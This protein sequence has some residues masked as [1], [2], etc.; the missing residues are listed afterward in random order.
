MD[1]ACNALPA[2]HHKALAL[3]DS[4]SGVFLRPVEMVSLLQ[5][6]SSP[7]LCQTWCFVMCLLG[8]QHVRASRML[9]HKQRTRKAAGLASSIPSKA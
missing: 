1:K 5:P 3:E 7:Q 2:F 4:T 6:P 8:H 9:V